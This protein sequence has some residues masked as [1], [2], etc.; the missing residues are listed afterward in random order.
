MSLGVD[1]SDKGFHPELLDHN[2][3]I[4]N[5][6]YIDTDFTKLYYEASVDGIRWR[7]Q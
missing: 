2:A 6:I 5:P 1:A 4:I 3:L 7:T